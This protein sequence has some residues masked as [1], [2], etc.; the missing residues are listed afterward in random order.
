MADSSLISA[1]VSVGGLLLGA[2]GTY[3]TA[4]NYYDKR[5]N[6][7][8]TRQREELDRAQQE[9]DR[10]KQLRKAELEQYA[11]SKTKEYAA[12]RDFEHLMR[13]YDALSVNITALQAFEDRRLK[14]L[15]DDLREIKG[16]TQTLLGML[17]GESSAVLRYLKRDEG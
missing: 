5:R 17:G 2:V 12:Q 4:R 6:D 15:E 10:Q 11:E 9:L 8:R 3:V 16:M 14:E 13:K 1:G 7:D